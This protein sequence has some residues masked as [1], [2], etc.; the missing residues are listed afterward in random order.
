MTHISYFFIIGICHVNMKYEYVCKID[1]I[2]SMTLQ[3]I[4]KTNR[5]GGT[6]TCTHGHQENNI[7]PQTQ[8]AEDNIY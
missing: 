7:T 8:F 6:H 4:K 2:P 5:Y 1:G 3:D